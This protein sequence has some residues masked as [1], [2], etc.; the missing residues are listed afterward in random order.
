MT[1]N[2]LVFIFAL[3]FSPF[4][5]AL[6]INFE[7][8]LNCTSAVTGEIYIFKSMQSESSFGDQKFKASF[9]LG[10]YEGE[11]VW[12]PTASVHSF[13]GGV[14][15]KTEIQFDYSTDAHSYFLKIDENLKGVL[16]KSDKNTPST[17]A[18]GPIDWDVSC[19]N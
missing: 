15:L 3:L 5:S 12:H 19:S 11:V 6:N 7:K 4:A 1:S 18:M 10:T 8:T 16:F 2:N 17:S 14:E 9:Q 13:E